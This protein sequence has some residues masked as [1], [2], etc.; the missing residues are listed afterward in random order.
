MRSI[1]KKNINLVKKEV[2]RELKRQKVYPFS[3]INYIE[4][5]EN[6]RKKLPLELWDIWEMADWEINR[7]IATELSLYVQGIKII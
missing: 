7:I 3:K 2:D 1:G 5:T 4:A 6:I